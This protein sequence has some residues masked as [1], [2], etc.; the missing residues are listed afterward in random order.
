MTRLSWT[1]VFFALA[2]TIP[3]LHAAD[4]NPRSVGDEIRG[5]HRLRDLR[6][7]RRSLRDLTGAKSASAATV[8]A[9]VSVKCPLAN[10][11][12]PKLVE[13]EKA[14][15]NRGVRFVAVYPNDVDT[16]DLV[17]SHM[18]DR[19]V[20]FLAVK[21]FGQKLAR[22]IGVRRTPA[23][24]VVGPKREL[25]YRGRIDDQFG[26]AYRREKPTK[27][28]LIDA[29]DSIVAKK[30]VDVAE[31]EEDGCVLAK[32]TNEPTKKNVTY[33]KDVA[34][35]LANRCQAC[36]R[37]G[38]IGPFSLETYEDANNWSD[39][40]REVVVERRMPPWHA[41]ERYGHFTN[42]RRLSKDEIGT[43]TS[44][45]DAGAP[46]GDPKD[47]TP[48]RKW[49]DDWNIGKPDAVFKMPTAYEVPATGVVP[50]KYFVVPTGFKE[51][52]W[53]RAAEVRPGDAAVVHHVIIY[54]KRKG[55]R[56]YDF[57]GNTTALVGWAP[58]DVPLDCSPD[59]AVKIPKDAALLFE[60]HYTPNG[61]KTSDQSEVGMIF[62]KK[63]P[64]YP[65]RKNIFARV[66]L[67]I[68]AGDSHHREETYFHFKKNARLVSLMP[69]MHLRGKAFRYI[70]EF[71]DG[72]K[73]TLLSVPR[74]DFNWQTVYTFE[75]PLEM[76]KGTRIHAIAHWDNSN[77]NP[78]NPDASKNVRYGL[79]TFEE[80]MNGW[81]GFYDV[82]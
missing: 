53:V 54:L 39:M 74:W 34:P 11:Y 41:D 6:G 66:N 40:I 70:A 9:F 19:D 80:M 18:Y 45:V 33:E 77:D 20:P 13:L 82:E 67:D 61:T 42:D 36:H 16:T 5:R 17:A 72:R 62:A 12:V 25:L 38:R 3:A 63:P 76:P 78:H 64:K 10:L 79:Q 47:A 21:D 65:A 7:N 35:I 37:P 2:S 73:E 57:E 68:P 32:P 22:E 75:K 8:F 43:I 56:L 52:R 50:Y 81:V 58:G 71:P 14:Y 24:A 55:E 30:K 60:V 51:D 69:H 49:T 1:F 23:V 59:T 29:L 31:T 46:R 44:W 4:E 48:T 27:T 15:R 28:E 26:I